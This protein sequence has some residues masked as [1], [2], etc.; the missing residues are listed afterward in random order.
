MLEI[1]MSFVAAVTRRFVQGRHTSRYLGSKQLTILVTKYGHAIR[2][3]EP[4]PERSVLW[5]VD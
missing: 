5:L 2:L 3:R 1:I 4:T